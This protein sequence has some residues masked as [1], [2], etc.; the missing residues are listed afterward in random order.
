M[1]NDRENAD[2]L[3]VHLKSHGRFLFQPIMRLARQNRDIEMAEHLLNR[4]KEATVNHSALGLVYS[5][6][7]DIHCE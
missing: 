1:T 2:K 6:I 5:C 4:C 3:W 7:V